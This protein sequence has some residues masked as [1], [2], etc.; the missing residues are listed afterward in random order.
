MLSLT[1]RTDFS[2]AAQIAPDALELDDQPQVTLSFIN[3][4]T[5]GAGSYREVVHSIACRHQGQPVGYVPHIFVTNEPA[6]LA[7]REWLGWPKLLADISFS[8][9]T[10]T[11]DGVI[12]ACLERPAGVELVVAEFVPAQ[13]LDDEMLV[14]RG[15][16]VTMNLRVIP[17]AGARRA[18]LDRGVSAVDDDGTVRRDPGRPWQCAA[19]RRV[20]VRPVAPDARGR[21]VGCC[22]GPQ[23]PPAVDRAD[24]DLP[25]RMRPAR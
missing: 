23:R 22:D 12:R 9:Q 10:T 8:T 13:R 1:Y 4:G 5:S 18:P 2:I 15:D 25:A 24:S 7:G 11:M 17:S 3:Y 6:V 16:N 21:D 20:G 14:A 19:H